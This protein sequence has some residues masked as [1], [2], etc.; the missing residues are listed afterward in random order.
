MWKLEAEADEADVAGPQEAKLKH[1]KKHKEDLI[2][3][4]ENMQ[5]EWIQK[6]T[7]LLTI[8][9]KSDEL[10]AQLND[11]KN[12]KMVLEQKKLRIESQHQA[13]MKEIK[14][15]DKTKED[16]RKDMVKMNSA[17]AKNDTKSK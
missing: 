13:H 12:R 3:E 17:I 15:L 14:E 8:S 1:M 5:K 9:T 11:Q 10:N 6:Q 16:L 4:C 7:Q 2:K